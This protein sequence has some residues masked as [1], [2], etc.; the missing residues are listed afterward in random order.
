MELI[1]MEKICVSTFYVKTRKSFI[2]RKTPLI[3]QFCDRN[4]SIPS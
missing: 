4:I 1:K 3:Q 2:M